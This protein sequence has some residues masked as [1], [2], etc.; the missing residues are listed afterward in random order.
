MSLL[1]ALT[2]GIP[3]GI[4]FS[5]STTDGSDVLNCNVDVAIELSSTT[6]D[7]SDVLAANVSISSSSIDFSSALNDGADVL[8]GS[9]D[10]FIGV[11]TSTTDGDDVL[12]SQIGPIIYFG[13]NTIDGADLLS[14]YVDTGGSSG[15][16]I[17]HHI[18]GM[19]GMGFVNI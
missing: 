11:N 14:A 7:G 5:S 6:N 19:F 1:L 13:S 12:V 9:V 4:D 10:V 2:G 16:D 15:S 3:T 18:G 17:Q 8:V